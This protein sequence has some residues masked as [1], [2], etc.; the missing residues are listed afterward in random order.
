MKMT[1]ETC[2]LLANLLVDYADGELSRA[3]AAE[4]EQHL[5]RCP[6]CRA[7]LQ[8]LERSLDLARDVWQDSFVVPPSGP[9][10]RKSRLKPVL[11]TS[12]AACAAALL[13]IAGFSLLPRKPRAEIEQTALKTIVDPAEEIDFQALLAREVQA[14]RLAASANLLASDSTTAPYDREALAYLASAYPDT[15]PGRQAA[16][17]ANPSTE[18]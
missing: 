18:P 13:L 6:V 11:R 8:R 12:L 3:Q 15:E 14:A 1:S 16:R 7:R 10:G 9:S 2:D 4:V 17:R 5:A